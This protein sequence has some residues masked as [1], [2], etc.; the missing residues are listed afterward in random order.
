MTDTRFSAAI[1]TLILISEATS[2][3][4]SEQIARS[5]GTNASYIRKLTALLNKGGIIEGRPGV[6]G[7]D[8]TVP[9]QK[10]TLYQVYQAIYGS[11][12]VH[13]FDL[14]RNPNDE[15][16]VGRYIQPVL[17]EVF[18]AVE[19]TAERQLKNTTLADCLQKMR[20]EIDM[21]VKQTMSE[22]SS[23]GDGQ[24]SGERQ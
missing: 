11:E 18:R 10:L 9:A 8:L 14:H 1:H 13:V 24:D 17:T 5:V 23:G 3:M 12:H 4:T 22:K 19:E 6:G 2:P 20:K 7:F 16:I 21:G 15:C